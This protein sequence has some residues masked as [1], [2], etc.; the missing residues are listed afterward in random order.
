[1]SCTLTPAKSITKSTVTAKISS[2]LSYQEA[3][4]IIANKMF[5]CYDQVKGRSDM[6]GGGIPEQKT[7]SKLKT[8]NNYGIIYHQIKSDFKRTY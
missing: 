6:M 1:M 2:N 4:S 7:Y 8:K 5:L 3:H